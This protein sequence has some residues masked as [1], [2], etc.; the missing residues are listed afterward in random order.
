[1]G[2]S[3]E[4]RYLGPDFSS[5]ASVRPVNAMTFPF[6]LAIGN[7]TRLRNFAYIAAVAGPPAPGSPEPGLPDSAAFAESGMAER[8]GFARSGP[9]APSPSFQENSPEARISSSLNS[10]FR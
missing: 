2:V 9:A 8:L 5:L 1:M 3:G 4:F 10:F 6:S 7:I